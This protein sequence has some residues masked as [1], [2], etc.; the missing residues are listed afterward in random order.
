[1]DSS[2]KFELIVIELSDAD[3]DRDVR[4]VPERHEYEL[5]LTALVDDLRSVTAISSLE[6][7]GN[8]IIIETNKSF[9][10]NDLKN[11]I[12]PYFSQDRFHQYRCVS[13]LPMSRT[14]S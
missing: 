8:S 12:K 11:I 4:F 1:M 14:E 7:N 9:K 6:V 2:I 13:L 3:L 10:A 5:Y